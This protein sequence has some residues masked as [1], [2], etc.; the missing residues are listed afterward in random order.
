M[1]LRVES[2]KFL[3]LS[4]PY[5]INRTL[6]TVGQGDGQRDS[7]WGV[8]IHESIKA[9]YGMLGPLLRNHLPVPQEIGGIEVIEK[10]NLIEKCR[11]AFWIF[12]RKAAARPQVKRVK[13]MG[14]ML[15]LEFWFLKWRSFRKRT[16]STTNISSHGWRAATNTFEGINRHEILPK[17]IWINFW[18]LIRKLAWFYILDISKDKCG[19]SYHGTADRWG[20]KYH[21]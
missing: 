7:Y 15:G 13:G 1:W 6:C 21:P 9:L 19:C 8:L 17:K 14:L 4:N 12:H 18:A 3:C 2:G 16:L 11:R 10:E 5:G 20:T